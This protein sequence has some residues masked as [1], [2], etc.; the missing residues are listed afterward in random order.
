MSDN[1]NLANTNIEPS[2]EDILSSIRKVI[3]EDLINKDAPSAED[4][5]DSADIPEVQI[6][7]EAD[8]QIEDETNI[9]DSAPLDLKNTIPAIPRLVDN[10]DTPDTEDILDLDSIVTDLPDPSTMTGES[11]E[12]L[13]LVTIDDDLI[14]EVGDNQDVK[15]EELSSTTKR[16]D[17]TEAPAAALDKT[18][19]ENVEMD[20]DE[21]LDL[22]MDADASDYVTAKLTASDLE[23]TALDAQDM[24]VKD[25][26]D[27]AKGKFESGEANTDADLQQA[28]DAAVK[29]TLAEDALLDEY[30]S[31]IEDTLENAL[32]DDT[33]DQ[34]INTEIDTTNADFDDEQDTAAPD[35]DMDLVKS[36]LN[37]LMDEPILETENPDNQA[38]NV[39]TS[40]ADNMETTDFTDEI[41]F[42]EG[43][44]NALDDHDLLIPE[45]S[46]NNLADFTDNLL[47]P[48]S[49]DIPEQVSPEQVSPEQHPD[50]DN[51]LA[52]IAK[53]VGTPNTIAQDA[54]INPD[55]V[56]T[57]E[58]PDLISKL[59]LT[60]SLAGTTAHV[61]SSLVHDDDKAQNAPD[62]THEDDPDHKDIELEAPGLESS[63]SKAPE[64]T[65]QA[66]PPSKQE[67][68]AMAIPKEATPIKSDT[69]IDVETQTEVGNAF[70]SLSSAVQEK[71]LAEENGP[72]IGELVKDAL[73]PMLQEW[74]DKN[75][76]AMVQRAVTKEIKR[77][78]S[79]K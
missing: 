56:V 30:F 9:A 34:G 51:T 52:Q 49:D 69:L 48:L 77:I 54:T 45:P 66:P 28:V 16:A 31:D 74:L 70:A 11:G 10:I 60:G 58:A 65:Q 12:A 76:K 33:S 3:A 27:Q 75:L 78:S 15:L 50:A 53:N 14:T 13:E 25:W 29:E 2:M 23:S 43:Q 4:S 6:K 44:D 46:D 22:V 62:S 63:T 68:E 73:K 20:F 21:S 57:L 64:H 7:A 61:A 59:A 40:A 24:G 35:E 42:S 55:D 26:R 72:P 5:S 36:L 41:L 38:L 47:A 71:A 18:G 1:S 32:G 39:K 8:P 19:G 37:D 17:N 67:E 79:G